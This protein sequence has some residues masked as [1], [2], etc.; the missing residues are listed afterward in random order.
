MQGLSLKEF[1]ARLGAI[2]VV[3]PIID[4]SYKIVE[5]RRFRED[6][7]GSPHG[8]KWNQ[9]FHASTFPGD[10][11]ACSRKAMYELMDVQGIESTGFD[12]FLATVVDA[13]KDLELQLVRR[14]RDAGFFV[15]SGQPGRSTDPDA[16]DEH[17]RP[18][19]Q[20]GFADSE[21]W[22]T[23][24]VDMPMLPYN[25]ESPLIVEIKTKSSTKIDEMIA[26]ERG[27]D[28]QHRHQLLTSLGLAHENPDAFLHPTEDRALKPA[29]D[30]SI[31]YIA[32][33]TD[34]PGPIKTF[35]FY[36]EYDP[37]FMAA[38]R[39]TLAKFRDHFIAGDLPEEIPRKNSRSHPFGW[40]WSQG[41]CCYCDLKKICRSDYDAGI[42]RIKDSNLNAVAMYTKNG[43]SHKDTR[44]AVLDA[45]SAE[46]HSEEQN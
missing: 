24:S 11:K 43:Y 13:G 36:F 30:G 23:G 2:R 21:H 40:K 18:M 22:L 44:Q 15:R 25:Y 12:R 35:E 27:P 9:S 38:G 37:D 5:E 20:V 1:M 34:W 3:E 41:L 45:W 17:G 39:R 28:P 42:T 4:E 33:D 8:R 10:K 26:G 46:D 6:F 14:V 29:V 31:Y 19:P 32:R 16:V 7:H